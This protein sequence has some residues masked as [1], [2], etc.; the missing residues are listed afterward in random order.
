MSYR[1]SHTVSRKQKQL[2]AISHQIVTC[3]VTESASHL[4]LV[5]SYRNQIVSHI[6]LYRSCERRVTQ[7]MQSG[8]FPKVPSA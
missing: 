1:S 6:E 2:Q 7:A 4:Q 3:H 5:C 8:S